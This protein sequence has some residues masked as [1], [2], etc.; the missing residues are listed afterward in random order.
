MFQFRQPA[1]GSSPALEISNTVMSELLDKI[2]L[3]MV[4]H[5]YHPT[6]NRIFEST[7]TSEKF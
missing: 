7:L 3:D 4:K 5:Q 2:I 6:R 1:S